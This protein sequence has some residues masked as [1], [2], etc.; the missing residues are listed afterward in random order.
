MRNRWKHSLALSLGLLGGQ[1]GYAAPPA[2]LARPVVATIATPPAAASLER[3]VPLDVS[4]G[5]AVLDPALRPTTYYDQTNNPPPVVRGQAPDL[6]GPKP[7]PAG[8]VGVVPNPAQGI[9][10]RHADTPAPAVVASSGSVAVA[11]H[12]ASASDAHPTTAAPVWSMVNANDCGADT[13]GGPGCDNCGCT[14]GNRFYATTDYVLWWIKGSKTPPLVTRGSASDT[15]PGA[16][17]LPGTNVLFGGHSVEDNPFSG[18]R[19]MVGYWFGDQHLFGIEGGGFFLGQQGK[20]FSA[21]SFGDPIL[22]RPIIDAA[23]G[24]ESTQ[25]VSG[26]GV[27]AGT[28]GVKTTSNLWGYEANLRSNFGCGQVCGWEFYVDGILGYRGLGLDEQLGVSESL[29]IIGGPNAGGRFVVND[30]FKVQNRFYG[31]Q[32]GTITE[33]RKGRWSFDLKTKVALGT[34]QEL[35]QIAGSTVITPPGGVG[36]SFNGGLLASPTNIGRYSRDRFTWIPELGLNIGYQCCDH[37]R[38]YVGYNALYWSSVVRPGNQID[39]TVNTNFLPPANGAGGP[40]RPQFSYNASDFW[41]QGVNFGL[42][43]RY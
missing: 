28:I 32:L 20:T 19:F 18:G 17:N 15:I 9:W 43:F 12:T 16:L 10:R 30:N 35:V 39:R 7:L 2:Q 25:L 6:T 23:T 31:G 21:T 33:F 40:A 41:A 26:P 5:A 36:Q 27:L 34:T 11:D 3:P 1:Y 24:T 4:T 14:F 29:V 8:P 38:L 22:T 13:C 37:L 42:E